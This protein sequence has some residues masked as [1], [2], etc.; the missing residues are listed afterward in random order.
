M[1]RASRLF[2][3]F[4]TRWMETASSWMNADNIL[5]RWCGLALGILGIVS[6]Y[7]LLAVWLLFGKKP[8]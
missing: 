7:P 5:L 6:M 1:N 2:E 4:L 8:R 3:R